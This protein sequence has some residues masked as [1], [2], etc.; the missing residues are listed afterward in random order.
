MEAYNS[1]PVM[2]ND[3]FQMVRL[4]LDEVA[5]IKAARTYCYIHMCDGRKIEL[6]RPMNKVLEVLPKDRFVQI[7]RSH[8]VAVWHIESV[9]NKEVRLDDNNHTC[10]PIGESCADALKGCF[11]V[12]ERPR[13]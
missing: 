6:S 1:K 2:L 13:M 3:G 12:L 11:I 4:N 5:Y 7:H 8:A 10:L 9:C